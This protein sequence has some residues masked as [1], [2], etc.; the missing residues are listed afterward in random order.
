MT[1]AKVPTSCAPQLLHWPSN[2]KVRTAGI[3]TA[4]DQIEPEFNASG[5]PL[6]PELGV[7]FRHEFRRADPAGKVDRTIDALGGHVGIQ[8]ERPPSHARLM[9]RARGQRELEAPFAEIAP[10]TNRIRIDINSHVPL[11]S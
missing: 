1:R 2:T 11:P 7:G 6:A 5:L 9:L 3:R 4:L 8:L 10:R